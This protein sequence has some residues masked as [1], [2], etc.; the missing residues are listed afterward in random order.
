MHGETE[1][2]GPA[3]MK[4][5][6]DCVR[7]KLRREMAISMG[8]RSTIE[9][10][11]EENKRLEG[12][13]VRVKGGGMDLE[14]QMKTSEKT[15]RME[16]DDVFELREKV[17]ELEKEIESL[18]QK[19]KKKDKELERIQSTDTGKKKK[20]RDNKTIVITEAIKLTCLK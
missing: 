13:S 19:L 1:G 20:K 16:Q 12:N 8:L 5:E 4:A 6:L 18:Q 15:K 2:Q 10:L 7:E 17:H 9:S 11:Q 3:D 14:D